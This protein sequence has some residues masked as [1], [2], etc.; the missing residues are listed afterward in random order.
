MRVESKI[1]FEIYQENCAGMSSETTAVT[2][3]FSTKQSAASLLKALIFFWKH[4]R[5]S[6]ISK[7]IQR[8]RWNKVL[9]SD[10]Y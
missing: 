10:S 1:Y 7:I 5:P 6:P 4:A 2:K 9:L 3:F 8:V